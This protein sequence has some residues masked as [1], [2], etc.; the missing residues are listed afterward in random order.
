MISPPSESL[1]LL[2]LL[3]LTKQD[4]FRLLPTNAREVPHAL[5]TVSELSPLLTSQETEG[6]LVQ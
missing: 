1:N 6:L 2:R 5:P 3:I 4:Q